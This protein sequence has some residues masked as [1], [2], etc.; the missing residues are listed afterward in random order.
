MMFQ[1]EHLIAE[2]RQDRRHGCGGAFHGPDQGR[3]AL[4]GLRELPGA[5]PA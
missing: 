2:G 4:A 5:C 3:I 1:E